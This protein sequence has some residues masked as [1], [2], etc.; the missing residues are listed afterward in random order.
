MSSERYKDDR[1]DK[2]TGKNL[3]DGIPYSWIL[4][5][6]NYNHESSIA[7]T[8]PRELILT[9]TKSRMPFL[10]D[11]VPSL[12]KHGDLSLSKIMDVLLTVDFKG[13]RTSASQDAVEPIELAH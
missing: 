4:F 7:R 11:E 12:A 13:I 9:K 2:A 10:R 8:C 1:I 5:V 6:Y 3:K